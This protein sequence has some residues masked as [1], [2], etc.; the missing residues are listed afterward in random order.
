MS[1]NCNLRLPPIIKHQFAKFLTHNFSGNMIFPTTIF[2]SILKSILVWGPHSGVLNNRSTDRDWQP[3]G[4]LFVCPWNPVSFPTW[5]IRA[6][7]GSTC[8]DLSLA[9][10]GQNQYAFTQPSHGNCWRR[11]WNLKIPPYFGWQS[12]SNFWRDWDA[13]QCQQLH[14]LSHSIITSN[15]FLAESLLI[16]PMWQHYSGHE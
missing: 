12:I 9:C 10:S 6:E 8:L 7:D 13:Y 15:S 4:P 16:K 14:I 3:S 5:D 1:R 11:L 2:F